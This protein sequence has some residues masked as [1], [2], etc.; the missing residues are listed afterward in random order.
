MEIPLR[1]ELT[2]CVGLI[3]TPREDFPAEVNLERTREYLAQRGW[4][5]AMI[6]RFAAD[7]ASYGAGAQFAERAFGMRRDTAQAGVNNQMCAR[8][9][10]LIDLIQ[11]NNAEAER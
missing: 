7:V 11:R 10:E 5:Q 6:D 1:E 8:N 4:P 9:A 3:A 2:Q